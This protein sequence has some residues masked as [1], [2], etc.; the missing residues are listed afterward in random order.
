MED[1]P[2]IGIKNQANIEKDTKIEYENYLI[3]YLK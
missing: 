3:L 2:Y 1:P